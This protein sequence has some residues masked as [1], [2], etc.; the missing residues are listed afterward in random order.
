MRGV[1]WGGGHKHSGIKAGTFG[2]ITQ[3]F[4]HNFS[5]FLKKRACD[6]PQ[7]FSAYYCHS[8][9]FIIV[10]VVAELPFCCC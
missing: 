6:E 5:V 4:S 10:H 2:F 1:R 3:N 8:S 7:C 9:S